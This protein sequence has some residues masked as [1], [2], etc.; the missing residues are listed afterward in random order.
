MRAALL[1]GA[2]WP[3]GQSSRG[4]GASS[5]HILAFIPFLPTCTI[6]RPQRTSFSLGAEHPDV[7][8]TDSR[9]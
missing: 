5:G 4:R 9:A 7:N 6:V 1:Q 3:P 8:G 2:S